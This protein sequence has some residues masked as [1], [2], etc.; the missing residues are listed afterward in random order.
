VMGRGILS[1]V[2][3]TLTGLTRINIIDRFRPSVSD[4]GLLM[5]SLRVSVLAFDGASLFHL[6]VPGMVLGAANGAP[7]LP[8]YEVG[9]CAV[10]PGR[11]RSDQGVV[12]EVPDGLE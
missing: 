4:F 7:D 10:A 8:R 12:I 5:P 3:P 6:S 2:A 9:Y 1:F 11:I